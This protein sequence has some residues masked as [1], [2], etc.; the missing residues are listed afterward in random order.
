M[1]I[2]GLVL[3][4]V[5]GC[6]SAGCGGS[7]GP[8][9]KFDPK[10]ESAEVMPGIPPQAQAQQKALI[11]LFEKIKLHNPTF[12]ALNRQTPGITIQQTRDDF[13]K[14]PSGQF[15]F[16]LAGWKWDGPPQGAEV[17]V[18]LIF[19]EDK[20]GYP[21]VEVKRVYLV[22]GGPGNFVVRPKP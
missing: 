22:A 14:L 7:S 9:K 11:T 15:A 17:P 1:Q 2:R 8:E 4:V 16:G 19:Q 3:A 12:D 5:L 13:F 20:P 21:T 18:T 10:A 6:V